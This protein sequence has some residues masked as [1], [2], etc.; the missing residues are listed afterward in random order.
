MSHREDRDHILKLEQIR[1]K[2]AADI[3]ADKVTKEE[4]LDP[5]IL[6]I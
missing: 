6:C 1:E 2:L 3:A 5:N 4:R